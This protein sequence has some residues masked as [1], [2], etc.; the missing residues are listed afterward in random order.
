MSDDSDKKKVSFNDFE[1]PLEKRVTSMRTELINDTSRF[2]SLLNRLLKTFISLL[3]SISLGSVLRT[4][5]IFIPARKTHPCL[6]SIACFRTPSA[7]RSNY[8]VYV[9]EASSSGLLPARS[10]LLYENAAG[11]RPMV[12]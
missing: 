1:S 9:R 10:K 2:V 11:I 4:F 12:S 7:R 3:F 6:M 5:R 8:D